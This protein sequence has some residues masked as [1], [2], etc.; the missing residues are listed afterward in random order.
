VSKLGTLWRYAR[1][2][3]SVGADEWSRWVLATMLPRFKLM[4]ALGFRDEHVCQVSLQLANRSV[5]FSF[6]SQD[7]FI[8]YEIFAGN[9]Y[10]PDWLEHMS[11]KVIADLGAHIGLATLQFKARF[12]EALVH[13][14]EPDPDNFRLLTRNMQSFSSVVLHREAVGAVS[15]ESVFHT[16]PER[17]S[18]SSLL[19][20]QERAGTIEVG[21]VVRSLDDILSELGGAD[22]VKFDIEGMEQEVFAASRLVHKVRFVVGEMK[23]NDDEVKR[24]LALFTHHQTHVNRLTAKMHLVY[25]WRR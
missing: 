7:I 13:C 19:T 4:R 8:L 11:P 12:P 15:G 10:C 9:P 22:L 14:Y 21:C 23:A 5:P 6:R 17:R 16:Q 20:P 1:L 2:G 25:L 3:R 24:F 18:A